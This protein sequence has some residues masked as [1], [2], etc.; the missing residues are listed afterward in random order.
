LRDRFGDRLVT[1]GDLERAGL[2]EVSV[3]VA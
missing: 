2:G 3:D 1:R